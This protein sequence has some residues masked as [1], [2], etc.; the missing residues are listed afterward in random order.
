M[1][2]EV[3]GRQTFY[4]AAVRSFHTPGALALAVLGDLLKLKYLG[5]RTA[6]FVRVAA[7]RS[8]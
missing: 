3:S 4:M 7:Y 8:G 1:L 2:G 6:L 5:L